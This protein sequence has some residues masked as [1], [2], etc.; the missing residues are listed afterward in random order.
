MQNNHQMI[1]GFVAQ[2]FE[3]VREAFIENFNSHNELG[4]ACAVYHKG[5]LVVDLW[6][7]IRDKK[8]RIALG[9]RHI[10]LS[11][12]HNQGDC[13]HGGCSCSIAVVVTPPVYRYGFFL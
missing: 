1:H 4:A 12:F 2:G 10:N 8:K 7:G 9:R 6:G 13:L 11:L 5:E 3:K